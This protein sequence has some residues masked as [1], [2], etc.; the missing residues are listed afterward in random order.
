MRELRYLSPSSIKKFLTD[1]ELFFTQYLADE[2]EER[3]PQNEAMATGS[4]FDAFIKAHLY[5]EL[6]CGDDPAF[7]LRT[8]F[9]SQVDE[10][11]WEFA[12]KAGKNCFDA[13]KGLG[14]VADLMLMLTDCTEPRFEF[15][16]EGSIDPITMK[17]SDTGITL[18]GKPDMY[19]IN[20]DGSGVILDWKVNGFCSKR[21]PSPCRGYLKYM[22]VDGKTKNYKEY[23]P[24]LINGV[25]CNASYYLE[26]G[27]EDWGRQLAIYGWLLGEAIGSLFITAIDQLICCSGT[28]IGVAQHRSRIGEQYQLDLFEN[29]KEIWDRVH[30]Q[31]FTDMSAMESE[32]RCKVLNGNLGTGEF[33]F[34]REV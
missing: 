11:N 26:N 5:K 14:C 34:R 10:H 32:E 25:M 3:E 16:L 30:G 2:R 6:A 22:G 1:Q 13:Y 18:L 8:L 33:D 12:W 20:A 23:L 9:E 29:I 17:L 21:K 28:V 27:N 15:K 4:A 24:T 7:E 19:F 31:F